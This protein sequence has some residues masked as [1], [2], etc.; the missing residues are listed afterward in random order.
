MAAQKTFRCTDSYPDGS[1][2]WTCPAVVNNILCP[3]SSPKEGAE[4]P[5]EGMICPVGAS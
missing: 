5:E 1:D 3:Y 4:I 2:G